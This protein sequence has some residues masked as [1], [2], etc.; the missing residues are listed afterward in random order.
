MALDPDNLATLKVT[1]LKAELKKRGVPFAGLK[2]KQALMDRLREDLLKEKEVEKATQDEAKGEKTQDEEKEEKTQDEV[3]E[4]VTAEEQPEQ[5]D[6][7]KDKPPAAPDAMNIDQTS[8]SPEAKE[9]EL[10]SCAG[11]TRDTESMNTELPTAFKEAEKLTTDAE[12]AQVEPVLNKQLSKALPRSELAPVVVAVPEPETE[13]SKGPQEASAPVEA[14][15]E[16]LQIETTISEPAPVPD[17]GASAAP[18]SQ[19]LPAEVPPT[20]LPV[21]IE[22][23]SMDTDPLDSLKRKRR[24]PSPPPS[25]EPLSP[26]SK[27]PRQSSPPRRAD[28]RFKN[29]FTESAPTAQQDDEDDEPA[30]PSMHPATKALYIRNLVRPMQEAN[31]KNHILSLS[32]RYDAQEEERELIESF[33]LDTIKSHALIVFTSV[34]AATRVRIGVHNKVFPPEKLRKPLWADFIP[35]DKVQSWIEREKERGMGARWEV[36]YDSI[37]GEVTAELIEVGMGGM[38]GRLA[39][40]MGTVGTGQRGSVDATNAPPLRSEGMFFDIADIEASAD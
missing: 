7:V 26:S 10:M 29:L 21:N 37:D 8:P 1:E 12:P 35:E 16:P 20:V 13:L 14:V 22:T 15:L 38:G 23:E 25:S 3:K 6:D 39:N 5:K 9:P 33:Y 34:A 31:L 32:T 4:E 30:T 24:S 2:L 27:K 18:T 36:A 17:A 40:R 11:E 28:N 19:S